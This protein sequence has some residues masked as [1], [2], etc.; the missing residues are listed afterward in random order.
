MGLSGSVTDS[1]SDLVARGLIDDDRAQRALAAKF[2]DLLNRHGEAGVSKQ[3]SLGWVFAN[4]RA[5]TGKSGLYVYGNVGG[6]KTLLM[7]LFFA[8]IAGERKKR[9]HFQEFMQEAHAAINAHREAYAAGKTAIKD[10]LR[11]AAAAMIGACEL[12]CIDEFVVNDIVDAMLLHRLFEALLARGVCVVT[13]SNLAPE[14]Q[15]REGLNRQLFLPFVDLVRRRLEIFHLDNA[16]DYRLE[17]ARRGRAYLTPLNERIAATME[18]MWHAR[19]NGHAE[20]RERIAVNGRELPVERVAGDAAW[21]TFAELCQEARG[22][23]DYLAIA[24]RFRDGLPLW[25]A[26]PAGEPAQRGA[27]IYSADR[28]AL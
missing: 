12:I 10:P 4:R 8:A 14:E 2:D 7:D 20:R 26:A 28:H 9:V 27:T 18:E 1:Y 17:G 22:A 5:K 19:A 25:R 6:G 21:F 11:P 15:Y 3:S 23:A 24:D 13:T 16:V